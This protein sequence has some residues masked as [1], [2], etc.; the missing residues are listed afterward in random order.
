MGGRRGAAR[1][2]WVAGYAALVAVV[3]WAIASAREWALA[4]LSTSQSVGEWQ[5]WREDVKEQQGAGGPVARRIPKSAEPPGLVLMRDYFVVCLVGA[6][7]FTTLLYWL[8]VW[9]VAGMT[10]SSGLSERPVLDPAHR[11]DRHPES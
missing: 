6:L 1:W 2:L 7:I 8:L 11:G 10:G 5:A 9:L 3:V 4:N